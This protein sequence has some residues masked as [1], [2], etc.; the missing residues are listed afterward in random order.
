MSLDLKY[1]LLVFTV[2]WKFDNELELIIK[3]GVSLVDI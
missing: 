1:H 2:P 3:Y